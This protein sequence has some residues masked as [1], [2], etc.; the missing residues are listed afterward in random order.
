MDKEPTKRIEFKIGI[1][2]K[3]DNL[4]TKLWVTESPRF[5]EFINS[6]VPEAKRVKIDEYLNAN[7]KLKDVVEKL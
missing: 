7:K 3:L 2:Y 4:E 6:L 1:S 5:F